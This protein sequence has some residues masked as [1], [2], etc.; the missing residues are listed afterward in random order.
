MSEEYTVIIDSYGYE[1][2]TTDEY[3]LRQ[4][5]ITRL[6]GS[7]VS[8]DPP[9]LLDMDWPNTVATYAKKDAL[10]D[11]YP[12]FGKSDVL[13]IGDYLENVV[14][15]YTVNGRL[16]CL[17]ISFTLNV[18][19]GR[20]SQVGSEP[21]W[22]FEE[23]DAVLEKYPDRKLFIRNYMLYYFLYDY[24]VN[25]FVD[26]ET[27][28]CS[29][30]SDEFREF[31]QWIERYK[32]PD[33]VWISF[34]DYVPADVLLVNDSLDDFYS[35]NLQR[36]R[37]GEDITI[38]GHVTKAGTPVYEYLPRC[39]VGIVENSKN[40]DG[41][42]AFLEYFISSQGS[43]QGQL[44]FGFPTNRKELMKMVEAEMEVKGIVTL[45]DGSVNTGLGSFIIGGD[46]V[47][48]YAPTQK[49]VDTILE[50][51]DNI[52]FTQVSSSPSSSLDG[53]VAILL[54]ELDPFDGRQHENFRMLPAAPAAGLTMF[55]TTCYLRKYSSCLAALGRKLLMGN[56]ILQQC[57][58]QF[59][60]Y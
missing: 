27:G 23:L 4:A 53:I 46:R 52:D 38:I 1:A 14:E 41:A 10:A 57:H 18:I 44:Q 33:E 3:E 2:T 6:N 47:P 20:T 37:F 21:G 56:G 22:T 15:G 12:Y 8:P 36:A 35:F 7:L 19:I 16:V 40:K 48:K 25:T 39:Q 26:Q 42:W 60:T 51:I 34:G 58:R 31:I 54:E 43:Y 49:D 30:D 17:P 29:F 45:P 5:A 28:K 9:D 55:V 50:V 24:Y 13:D 11:L 32:L 59:T